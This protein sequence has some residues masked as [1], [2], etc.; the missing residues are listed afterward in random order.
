MAPFGSSLVRAPS[1]FA[2]TGHPKGRSLLKIVVG[3]CCKM[4][5]NAVFSDEPCVRFIINVEYSTACGQR[6]ELM[7]SDSFSPAFKLVLTKSTSVR[8]LLSAIEFA[9]G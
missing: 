6:S 3:D 2:I 9:V 1:I 8:Q 4:I 5:S 7:Y